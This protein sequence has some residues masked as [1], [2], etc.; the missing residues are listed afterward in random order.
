MPTKRQF[1][2]YV[3]IRNSGV[4]NMYDVKTVC[5]LSTEGLTKEICFYII[6][7]FIELAELFEVKI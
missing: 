3:R 2:D 4:T 1:E 5:A 6:H 7:N